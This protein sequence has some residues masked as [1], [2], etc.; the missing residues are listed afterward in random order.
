MVTAQ[1]AFKSKV[2]TPLEFRLGSQSYSYA[3][4]LELPSNVRG[5]HEAAVVDMQFTNKMLEWLGYD[6]GDIKY[7]AAFTGRPGSRP[8]FRVEVGGSLAFVVEDK[9]TTEKFG[10][11]SLDQLRRYTAGTSGYGLW[12]NAKS[13]IGLQFDPNGQ[14]KILVEVRVDSAFGRQKSL[15]PQEANFEILHF[16]FQKKRFTEVSHLIQDI[17]IDEAVWQPTPLTSEESLRAFI[18]ESRFVL[19]QLVTDVQARLSIVSIELDEAAQDVALSQQQFAKIVETLLTKLKGGGGV[20]LKELEKLEASLHQLEATLRDTDIAQVE[21]LKPSMGTATEIIWHNAVR[22]IEAVVS[23]LRERDLTRTETRRIR[24]AYMVWRGRYRVIEGTSEGNEN[25]LEEK[26]QRAFAE[27]VSYVFFIRLLL[28]RVLEDKGIMPRLVSDGG[29]TAWYGFL[30]LYDTDDIKEIRGSSFLPLVYHRVAGFYRHFFQ[31]PVFDWFLPDDYLVVLVLHQLN[32]YSFK[33]VTSDILGFTYEAFIDRVARNSKGHFLT[34]PSIVDFMLD[35]INYND[36]AIIGENLIDPACGS[37]SFLVHCARRLRHILASVMT[38]SS[39]IE[40]AEKFI[41]QV[42]TKLVGLEINPF[43]CYLAELNLFIQ[44]LDDLD[45]LWKANKRPA[46]ERF[47][48]FNTNSLEM[49]QAV[50]QSTLKSTANVLVNDMTVTLDEAAPIKSLQGSF[51]YVICNP[52]YIN[53]G[54]ILGAKSYGDFPFYREVVKGDE[55]FYL[56]FLRLADYYASPQGTIC[57][58]CPLNLVG[59]ESTARARSIFSGTAWS[60]QSVTR[61]YARNVLFAG[62]L[63]G[64]CIV[65]FDKTPGQESDMVEVRGGYNIEDAREISTLVQRSR[66][67]RNYPTTGNWNSPWLVNADCT[68]Y[69]IW[70]FVKTRAQRNLADLL[71]E[72]MKMKEGD[73]RS[74]W[75]KPLMVSG[76]GVHTVPL[77]KGKHI[78]DWGDWSPETHLDP[79]RTIPPTTKDYRSSVWVQE[80]V[81]RVAALSSPETVLFL[82][83]VSGLEMKRPIR[84]TI[85][86]R[87]RLHPV[88]ADHTVLVLYTLDASY[89]DLAY[90]VFGL[91]TSSTYNFL[92][93]LFS[94][95]AHVNFKEIMRLPIPQWSEDLEREIASATKNAL[96]TYKELHTHEHNFGI[97]P[98]RQ[99]IAVKTVLASSGL[100]TLT[101]EELVLRGDMVLDGPETQGLESLARRGKLSMSNR[102]SEEAKQAISLLIAANAGL[103]YG[104]GGSHVAVPH[105]RIAAAFLARIAQLNEE[106]RAKVQ[107]TTQAQN[108]LDELVFQAYG[109]TEESWKN[110]IRAGVPWAGARAQR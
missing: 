76:P 52:P 63:Q 5:G 106:R 4:Y 33:N 47:S 46:I 62:V 97:S 36:S 86:Q 98:D 107:A 64:I 21:L 110:T 80:Q 20:D 1:E 42:T 54:I 85:L 27:Q 100:Q 78:T 94:T 103:P 68:A 10:N 108:D 14:H 70:E 8:D 58:I 9:S 93:S 51:S 28:A 92:F 3:D 69:D 96:R 61:F 73:A 89:E 105:P 104:K 88:V 90:T 18:D 43:S 30:K 50:L 75:A 72:K 65:R 79:F 37:G 13:I 48:I 99:G 34:P 38:K 77:T 60:I 44:I 39:P 81:Q 24:S 17:A 55:N 101:I 67:T 2:I 84:G 31:Q 74:T 35:R 45:L 41:D 25:E 32:K 29:F 56:L 11:A 19:D 12:T 23:A 16:L 91:L 22:D 66:I 87:D 15:F 57:F 71:N 26:R 59:D 102:L 49:P 40:I 95:N 82:K 53:R 6:Q 83:E 109:L 7:N